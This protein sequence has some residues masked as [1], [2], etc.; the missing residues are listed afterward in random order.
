MKGGQGGNVF[1][2]DSKFLIASLKD[3][4][5]IYALQLTLQLNLN[6]LQLLDN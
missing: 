2:Y 4:I 3:Q 5:M 1:I 6:T